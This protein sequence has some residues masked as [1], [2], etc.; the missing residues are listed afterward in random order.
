[1]LNVEQTEGLSFVFFIVSRHNWNTLFTITDSQ[2]IDPTVIYL[3]MRFESKTTFWVTTYKG[4][5]SAKN[6]CLSLALG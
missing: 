1:M 3:F 6:T 2:I 5:A 4:N